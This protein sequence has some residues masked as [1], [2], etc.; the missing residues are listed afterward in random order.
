MGL[1][2]KLKN[3]RVYKQQSYKRVE[4]KAILKKRHTTKM[5]KKRGENKIVIETKPIIR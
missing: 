3:Q 1:V 2:Q 4:K 5:T